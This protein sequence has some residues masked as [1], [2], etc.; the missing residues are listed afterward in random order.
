M[1]QAFLHGLILSIGLIL[2]MGPQNL[3]IFSQGAN[4]P[5]FKQAIPVVVTA[6]VCDLILISLAIVGIS[7]MIMAL[8]ILQGLLYLVG[9]VFLLV[10][11]RSI[12]CTPRVKDQEVKALSKRKQI[13]FAISVSL[14]NPH[15]IMDTVGVIGT[16]AVVYE[17]S[18][19]RW[20]F[21]FSCVLVSWVAFF[22]LAVAGRLLRRLDRSGKALHI[23]HKLSALFIWGVAIYLLV[24]GF[25]ALS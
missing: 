3:F 14:L 24:N 23:I 22:A 1:L 4:Q 7:V 20:A 10:I 15:A 9:F 5:R 11:G 6:G 13:T 19:E 17:L 25:R 2:P 16:N 18:S 12:W 21:W 8:P